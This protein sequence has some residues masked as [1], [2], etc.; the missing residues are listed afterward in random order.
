MSN[1]VA[2]VALYM[3]VA[4]VNRRGLKVQLRL[5]HLLM[6]G[7]R[8]GVFDD[9]RYSDNAALCRRHCVGLSYYLSYIVLI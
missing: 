2:V 9:A 3:T 7:K 8:D 5:E 1:A 6:F 4:M